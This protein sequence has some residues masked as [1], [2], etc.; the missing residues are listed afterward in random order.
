VVQSST[1]PPVEW[2]GVIL[3]GEKLCLVILSMMA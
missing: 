2:A 1:L 3:S